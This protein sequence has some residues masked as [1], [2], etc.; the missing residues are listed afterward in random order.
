[1][2]NQ[3]FVL[4]GELNSPLSRGVESECLE[5][6]K[7]VGD[8]LVEED[9]I[10]IVANG[11]IF[12]II[13]DRERHH[14]YAIGVDCLIF[15]VLIEFSAEVVDSYSPI[16]ISSNGPQMIV[17]DRHCIG[18]DLAKIYGVQPR[19]IFPFAC[20]SKNT[21]KPDIKPFNGGCH[22]NHFAIIS[23]G[24]CSALR[25]WVQKTNISMKTFPA[26][27]GH[28]LASLVDEDGHGLIEGRNY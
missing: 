1:M 14:G 22:N 17:C 20:L 4:V 21:N 8:I 11:Q 27:K 2:D 5:G 12:V 6:G 7:G 28:P 25:L 19:L 9:L 3:Q 16:F 10:V 23:Y 15:R 26:F 18:L 24:H 13:G